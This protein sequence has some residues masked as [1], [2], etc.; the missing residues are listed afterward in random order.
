MRLH[1]GA[2][3][4]SL[5]CRDDEFTQIYCFT[6]NNIR[7]GTG[8]CMYISGVPGTGK[9]ATVKEVMRRLESESDAGDL[10]G[11]KFIGR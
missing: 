7:C 9:T 1:V 10:P 2:V 4:E 8:G 5:P 11:F 6:E 3:P